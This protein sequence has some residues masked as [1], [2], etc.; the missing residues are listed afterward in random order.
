MNRI[1]NKNVAGAIRKAARIGSVMIVCFVAFFIS[2][3]FAQTGGQYE[4]SWSTIDGGGTS[5]GGSYILSGTIGQPDAA[6]SAGGGY[7][8]FGG[9]LPYLPTCWSSYECAGQPFGDATCNGVV[10]ID[11]LSAL[12]AAWGMSGPYA[13][14]YCCADFTQDGQV[15]LDDLAALKAGWGG[16]GHIPS[17]GSQSCPP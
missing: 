3:A 16:S 8:V 13:A 15:N 14:P 9:F 5:T 2:A 6:Y 1:D 7:E 11:D 4:L 12:Q 10:N 17:T